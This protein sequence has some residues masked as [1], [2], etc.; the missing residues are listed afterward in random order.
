M[1]F[2]IAIPGRTPNKRGRLPRYISDQTSNASI[3][4]TPSGGTP[5]PP[6]LVNCQATCTANFTANVGVDSFD[7]TL[8]DKD[9]KALSRGITTAVVDASLTNSIHVTF[10]GIVHDATLRTVPATLPAGTPATALMFVDAHDADG[11]T[12]VTDGVYVDANGTQVLF[13]VDNA[14]ITGTTSFNS[15]GVSAPGTVIPVP[16]QR[17]CLVRRADQP[18]GDNVSVAGGGERHDAGHHAGDGVH[19]SAGGLR[20]PGHRRRRRPL[21]RLHQPGRRTAFGAPRA[22]V[23][24][25]TRAARGAACVEHLPRDP[26]G[27]LR[28]LRQRDRAPHRALRVSRHRVRSVQRVALQRGHHDRRFHDGGAP[29]AS[30]SA[31]P[32]AA[33]NEEIDDIATGPG[34]NIYFTSDSDT[35]DAV[36]YT[37]LA[38]TAASEL[39][40]PS[41]VSGIGQ[42]V[43]G[44]DGNMWFTEGAT[45]KVGKFTPP[46]ASSA[47]ITEIALPNAG[48]RPF[49]VTDSPVQN[50]VIVLGSVN[51]DPNAWAL[52]KVGYTAGDPASANNV[53]VFRALLP[54]GTNGFGFFALHG[55]GGLTS[56][57]LWTVDGTTG[58]FVRVDMASKVV[59]EFAAAATN[60]YLVDFTFAPDGSVYYVG[61]NLLGVGK[62]IP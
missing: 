59:T 50:A 32:N 36:G 61:Q 6:V 7:V 41:G 52:W 34:P 14:D 43:A 60:P 25:G 16:L 56:P 55:T 24:A 28:V 9:E 2:S 57:A 26:R 5:A 58:N 21:L 4:Y 48:D 12:I 8:Y 29:A 35:G 44:S 31:L 19:L 10:N 17:R 18:D 22:A 54:A 51:G 37:D 38:L 30:L 49:Y 33:Q 13:R 45:N 53:T 3:V 11:D 46:G 15:S 23:E 40:V 27:A 62:L 42:I 20:L 1:S 39:P 47:S